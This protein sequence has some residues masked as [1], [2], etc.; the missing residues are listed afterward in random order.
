MSG[1]QVAPPAGPSPEGLWCK[2]MNLMN[3]VSPL[4]TSQAPRTLPHG[5]CLLLPWHCPLRFSSSCRAS[6]RNHAIPSGVTAPGPSY[7]PPSLP[8]LYALGHGR[9][10]LCCGASTPD[11]LGH[12]ATSPCSVV[13]SGEL[14]LCLLSVGNTRASGGPTQLPSGIGQLI[15]GSPYC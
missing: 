8:F 1:C 9:W 6:P 10:S 11:A 2:D 5:S 13:L 7:P 14:V 15:S 4:L 3:Q 12:Q